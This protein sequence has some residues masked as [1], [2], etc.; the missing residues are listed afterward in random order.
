MARQQFQGILDEESP[1][2][3]VNKA[4][5]LLYKALVRQLSKYCLQFSWPTLMHSRCRVGWV[6]ERSTCFRSWDENSLAGKTKLER[7]Y[8]FLYKYVWGEMWGKAT[9][10]LKDNTISRSDTYKQ[11]WIN[12]KF[13]R[14]LLAIS[15]K[16]WNCL[17]TRSWRQGPELLPDGNL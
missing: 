7:A 10:M 15:A 9:F 14:R 2:K 8:G 16:L 11:L 1:V 6:V 4:L 12:E 17:L 3:P 13:K 5:I